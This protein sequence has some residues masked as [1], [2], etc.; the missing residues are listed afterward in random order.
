[1]SSFFTLLWCLEGHRRSRLTFYNTLES[2]YDLGINL[3]NACAIDEAWFVGRRP[4][5]DALHTFLSPARRQRSRSV[6]ILAGLGG[7]G[8]SQTALKFAID[9][10]DQF[11]SIFWLDAT[12]ES[13]MKRGLVD[14]S[15]H[16]SELLGQTK[17]MRSESDEEA[18]ILRARQWLSEP[19]NHR[20]LLVMDNYDDPDV[21]GLA[22]ST[23]YD[24]RQFYP[25][26]SQ[27]SILITS[28]CSPTALGKVIPVKKLMAK[29][30]SL[31]ILVKRSGRQDAASGKY[32]AIS[33]W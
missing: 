28:R 14:I 2:R 22:S 6:A 20:W 19:L 25:L 15:Y 18:E 11:S 17:E 12:S 16:I 33:I 9:H 7:T 31:D 23:G 1:M 24:I 21:P 3:G 5:L 32:A 4:E 26:R 30:E 29:E 13:S 8:K 27:G 10:Q